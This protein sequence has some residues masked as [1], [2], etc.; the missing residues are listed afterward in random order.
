[1]QIVPLPSNSQDAS[2]LVSPKNVI[3]LQAGEIVQAEVLTVTETTVAVRMKSTIL[4]ARTNLPLKEGEVLSLLVEEAGQEI[5]LRLLHG[6][7][8]GSARAI[9]ATI[10]TALAALKDL[11][12]AAND[13]KLLSRFI[14]NASQG[15]RNVMP[16]LNM[17]EKLLPSLNG[18]SGPVLKKAVENSGVF[19]EAKLRLLAMGEKQEHDGATVVSKD[20]KAALLML[21]ESL[22]SEE[23]V[24]RL[25]QSGIRTERLMDAVD[26]LLK[27]TELVQLQ[28]RLND[29][30]QV[31]VPFVWQDLKD[32]ELVFR[33]SDRE[34]SGDRAY[35]CT[36]NLDLDSVG[37]VSARVLLQTGGIYVDV[38]AE[39]E[40]FSRMLQDGSAELTGRFEAAGIRLAGLSIRRE[41]G[42][43]TAPERAGGLSLRV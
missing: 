28:S 16:E 5:R 21:K 1:V 11:K 40:R 3:A 2:V 39:D 37:K 12:P 9:R 27:N 23:L 32:G 13:I 24:D 8:E 10:M 33:E 36:V 35:S 18:M 34:R 17:L 15:L 14:E 29:T 22:G 7:G 43:E 31:F 6:N 4:E 38:L 30:L 19:F 42:I 25:I 41:S 20:M 26:N